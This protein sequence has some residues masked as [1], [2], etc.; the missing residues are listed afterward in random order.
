LIGIANDLQLLGADD[1]LISDR[2]ASYSLSKAKL[3]SVSFKHYHHHHH[4]QTTAATHGVGHGVVVKDG[5]GN[6]MA[7]SGSLESIN[8]YHAM[9]THNVGHHFT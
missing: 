9:S 1:E 2:R 6:V 3:P 5:S 8:E 4:H 7:D